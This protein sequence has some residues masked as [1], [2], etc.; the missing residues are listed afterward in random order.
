MA[1]ALS[2]AIGLHGTPAKW[3]IQA[4]LYVDL[5]SD[6]PHDLLFVGMRS[7]LR[8]TAFFPKPAEIRAPIREELARRNHVVRRLGTALM[9]AEKADRSGTTS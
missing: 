3:E 8:D 6:L 7:A 4:P 5:L 2:F 9:L 1:I